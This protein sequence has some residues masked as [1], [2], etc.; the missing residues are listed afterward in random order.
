MSDRP[1]IL[2]VEDDLSLA[3]S[4]PRFLSDEGFEVT[5]AGNLR[6]ARA[7][8]A[9]NGLALVILDWMLPDGQGIDLLREYRSS[10]G[11]LPVLL[12]TARAELVDKVLGL[13]TGANDYLT[14]PF[15]P[16]ELVARIRVQL[17]V[18]SRGGAIPGS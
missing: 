3:K 5:V 11:T 7:E 14:K 18:P 8:L 17:R 9:A 10:G 13:E 15:E 12:L 4:I 6:S 2:L 16:R 1:K